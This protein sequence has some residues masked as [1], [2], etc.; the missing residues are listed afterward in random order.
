MLFKKVVCNGLSLEIS[1]PFN[2]Q[3][4]H[5]QYLCLYLIL[6][7]QVLPDKQMF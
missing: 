7:Y 6:K 3:L 2:F 1:T 4:K 5:N